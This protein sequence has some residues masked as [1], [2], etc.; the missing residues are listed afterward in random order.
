MAKKLSRKPSQSQKRKNQ[1][2]FLRVLHSHLLRLTSQRKPRKFH[3]SEA[4]NRKEVLFLAVNPQ[5]ARSLAAQLKTKRLR[6][7]VCLG[8]LSKPQLNLRLAA[9][10]DSQLLQVDPCL[11]QLMPRR[12]KKNP[13]N[14]TRFLVGPSPLKLVAFS[15]SKHLVY[16]ATTP[17]QQHPRQ[18]AC[19]VGTASLVQ[20][21]FSHLETTKLSRNQF[22][23]LAPLTRNRNL[24]LDFSANPL[25]FSAVR[26]KEP[27][28]SLESV[29]GA[30]K[31]QLLSLP[32]STS[33]ARKR[34]NLTRMQELRSL[35]RR[36]SMPRQATPTSSLSLELRSRSL[37]TPK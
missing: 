11:E 1:R 13:L 3:F 8:R 12:K 34:K 33:P 24:A 4:T 10:L 37:P 19:L 15:H 36:Q 28:R 7:P 29:L 25:R 20:E 17:L 31:S 21:V 23:G 32:C 22:S 16:S 18:V 35:T 5:L 6:A 30:T 2:N 14:Q 27:A 9:C 26:M